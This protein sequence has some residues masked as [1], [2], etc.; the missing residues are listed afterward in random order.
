M[1][2]K[3]KKILEELRKDSSQTT[4]AIAKKT[5]IPITTV[6]KRI[7]KLRDEGIIK[8]YTIEVDN[9]K[10]E[11]GLGAVIMATLEYDALKKQNISQKELAR[12][13]S[14]IEGVEKTF[15]ITGGFDMAIVI[16]VKDTNELERF[17][18]DLKKKFDAID[19]TQTM[20]VLS[21]T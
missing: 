10:L 2:E 16:R 17:I 5:L 7:K 6:H 3:D 11:K 9:S 4:R 12:K 8:H 14:V 1:D 21:E 13:I 20:I 18:N 19:R 15:H